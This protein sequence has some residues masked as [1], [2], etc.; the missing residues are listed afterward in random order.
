MVPAEPIIFTLYIQG[1]FIV[2]TNLVGPPRV[3]IKR[4]ALNLVPHV[5][6]GQNTQNTLG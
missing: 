3:S 5:L 2:R 4:T 6:N 1:K